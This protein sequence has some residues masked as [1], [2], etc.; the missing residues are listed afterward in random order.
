ML[1]FDSAEVTREATDD[2]DGI[3]V[4]VDVDNNKG[5]GEGLVVSRSANIRYLQIEKLAW[6]IKR[7]R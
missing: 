6:V 7:T 4:D 5:T 2:E 1:C 3:D